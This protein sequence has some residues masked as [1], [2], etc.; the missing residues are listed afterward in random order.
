MAD[1][2]RL[3]LRFPPGFRWGTATSPTQVEGRVQNEW[4]SVIARD[5]RTCEAACDSY[6]RYPEDIDWMRRLGVNAYRFGIEWSRLQPESGGALNQKELDRYRNQLDLLHNAGIEPMPVLHHFSNPPW[7]NRAGAWTERAT[8]DAFTDYLRRLVPAL[9]GHV[10]VWNTFN[11]PETYAC[12]GYLVGEFPPFHQARVG[13]C[14]RVIE[15]MAAA[16]RRACDILRAAGSALGPVEVGFSKNWT[17]YAPH[18][19]RLPWDVVLADFAH[20]QLNE[21]VLESFLQGGPAHGATFLG[22]NYY[23]RVRFRHCWPLVPMC[24][25]TPE[26]LAR[27]GIACDDMLERHPAG[28]EQTLVRLA[29]ESGLPIYVTEHGSAST[30]EAFREADLY[31]NLAALHRA[32]HRG[33]DVR[34]FYYW[35]LLDNFEWQFGYTK[36]FGLLAVNFDDPALPRSTKPLARTYE[37]ICRANALPP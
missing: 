16:H 21:F 28:L 37:S 27:L 15:N 4:T 6:H 11:E 19:D 31:E 18:D 10:R 14:R 13:A 20:Q 17:W 25:F 5:G 3:P 33:V 32:L 7:I 22:V 30:D 12:C 8:V 29:A 26:Y 9:R 23:G 1:P 36:K 2:K 34:G 35:S 24:G